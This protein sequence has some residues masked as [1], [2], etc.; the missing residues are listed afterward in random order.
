M[1]RLLFSLLML[2]ACVTM[3]GQSRV[4]SIRARLLDPADRSVLVASHRGEWS[5]AKQNS[6]ASI[7]AAIALGADIVEIDVRKT[8][9]GKLVLNHDP[10]LFSPPGATM[11]EDALL[12]A[13]GRIMVNVDKAFGILQ[14]VIAIARKTGTLDHLIVKGNCSAYEAVKEL[15]AFRDSVI[16]MPVVHFDEPSGAMMI[17]EYENSL[18]PPIY[19]FVYSS[20]ESVFPGIY[21]RLFSGK[22]RIWYNTLWGSI[23]GG[24]DDALSLKDPDAGYGYLID[25]LG[26]GALQTDKTAYLIEYLG[27]R[28]LYGKAVTLPDPGTPAADSD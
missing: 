26:A 10:V 28:N 19:E 6:V 12:C 27:N 23:C 22:R 15:G 16:F 7:E 17:Q 5:E 1:K 14:D 3:R 20:P 24:H 13:K 11:L 9:G 18:C 21:A 4:D 8:I 25:T 2:L